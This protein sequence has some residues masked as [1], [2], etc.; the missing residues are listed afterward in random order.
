LIGIMPRDLMAEHE[1]F[2]VHG[3]LTMH[4]ERQQLQHPPS[5]GVD[6][7]PPHGHQP[8]P[9]NILGAS[10]TRRSTPDREFSCLWGSRT[11]GQSLMRCLPALDAIDRAA[12]GHADVIDLCADPA[13]TRT[14]GLPDVWPGVRRFQ[15]PIRHMSSAFA[16]SRQRP[17][18]DTGCSCRRRV[19]PPPRPHRQGAESNARRGGF[20]AVEHLAGQRL[21]PH[22]GGW[23]VA[24]APGSAKA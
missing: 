7:R 11:R 3:R 24:A 1:Q 13:D 5:K 9:T 20:I 12:R 14:G 23:P 10:Q 21:C 18:L 19:T 15:T 6:Q 4:P 2:K 16:G 8:C 17:A 22:G